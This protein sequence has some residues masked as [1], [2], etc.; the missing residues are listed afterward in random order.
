[1]HALFPGSTQSNLTIKLTPLPGGR[2]TLGPT[3]DFYG[4][5]GKGTY[6]WKVSGD[7]LTITKLSGPFCP[8]RAG[9]FVGSW[10]KK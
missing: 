9:L 7:G 4:C 1:V 6:G 3:N 5:A 8:A 10:N 2:L